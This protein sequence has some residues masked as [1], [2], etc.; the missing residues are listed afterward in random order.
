ME[1]RRYSK[2]L[3]HIATD[4]WSRDIKSISELNHDAVEDI[5][6]K[7]GEDCLSTLDAILTRNWNKWNQEME[8]YFQKQKK[9]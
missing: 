9:S 7:Y 4:L 6:N 5:S 3:V 8:D 2:E 1:D